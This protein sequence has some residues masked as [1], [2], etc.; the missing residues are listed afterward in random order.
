M[1]I[2]RARVFIENQ[3]F[4][5]GI[6]FCTKNKKLIKDEVRWN[7]LMVRLYNGNNQ[8]RKAT[9]HL[10]NLLMLNS[11]NCEYYHGIVKAS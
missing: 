8:T 1:Y 2:L 10:E 9:E 5:K 11:S 3:E 4:K 7:E 6:K